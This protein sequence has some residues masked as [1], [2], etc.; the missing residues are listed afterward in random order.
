MRLILARDHVIELAHPRPIN[1]V[2]VLVMRT[3]DEVEV[4]P[5]DKWVMASFHL[6]HQ[7]VQELPRPG[8]V[9]WAVDKN[10]SPDK[11]LAAMVNV[12]ADEETPFPP[13]PYLE[14][15]IPEP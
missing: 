13:G 12:S 15:F 6:R 14:A 10:T 11:S 2:I 4:A 1:V 3:P 8:V 9:G 5:N 7:L